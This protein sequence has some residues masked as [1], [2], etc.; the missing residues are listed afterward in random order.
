MAYRRHKH[1]ICLFCFMRRFNLSKFGQNECFNQITMKKNWLFLLF[2]LVVAFL[3]FSCNNNKG[4]D[5]LV[6]NWTLVGDLGGVARTGAVTFTIGDT[7]YVGLG[8]NSQITDAPKYLNDFYKYDY[9][10]NQWTKIDSFPGT[11]RSDAVG[12]SVN[13]RGY[14]GTGWDGDSRLNDFYEYDPVGN[15]HWKKVKELSTSLQNGVAFSLGNNGY[16]GTGLSSNGEKLGHFW[17][18]T[19]PANSSD[20]GSWDAVEDIPFKRENAVAFVINNKAYVVTG[21][22][23][24][25]NLNSFYSYDPDNGWLKLREISNV[26]TNESYDDNYNI[27]R[28]NGT[29]MVANGKGYVTCGSSSGTRGDTWE[30]DPTT[31]LWTQKTSFEGTTRTKAIGFSV[32]NRMFLTTGNNGNSYYF[33]DVWEFKPNDTYD[34]NN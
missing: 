26:N 2:T 22:N 33:D 9:V 8:Y 34:A 11:R 17:K 7:V 18:F 13:N 29:A 25:S 5:A 28:S 23:N 32:N 21:D 19:P 24:G 15:P 30:Y 6:G 16:V 1:L 12:F 10:K 27:I 4:T 31:D 20:M 14:V 3:Q